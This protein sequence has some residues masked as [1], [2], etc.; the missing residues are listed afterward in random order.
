MNHKKGKRILLTA[1]LNILANKRKIKRREPTFAASLIVP[2]ED[3]S[4]LSSY[5]LAEI[6]S[7]QQEKDE[8]WKKAN[9][10]LDSTQPA[11][12]SLIEQGLSTPDPYYLCETLPNSQNHDNVMLQASEMEDLPLISKESDTSTPELSIQ[13]TR[14]RK[15]ENIA[16]SPEKSALPVRKRVTSRSNKIKNDSKNKPNSVHN[17][18]VNEDEEDEVVLLTPAGSPELPRQPG[19]QSE[20]A[21][22]SAPILNT[23]YSLGKALFQRGTQSTSVIGRDSERKIINDFLTTRLDVRGKGALYISGLPGTGKSALLNEVILDTIKDCSKNYPIRMANINCMTMENAVD[24]FTFIHRELTDNKSQVGVPEGFYED[25]DD[26]D[27]EDDGRQD[28]ITDGHLMQDPAIRSVIQDLE[29]RFFSKKHLHKNR[30]VKTKGSI[31]EKGVRHVIILD[32]LDSIMTRDQEVLFRIFQWAFARDSSLILFGIANALDLT[33]RFLPRLRSSSL[34]PQ[35]LP[36]KPYN[37]FQIISIISGRLWSLV[38]TPSSFSSLEYLEIKDR[39]KAQPPLIDKAAIMLCAKKIAANTGDLRKAF[40][41]CRRSLELVEEDVRRKFAF[42]NMDPA[43]VDMNS[44][45]AWKKA[46]LSGKC[47]DKMVALTLETAPRVTI[48]HVGRV[49]AVMFESSA[50]K[51]INNLNL[52]QKAVLCTLAISERSPHFSQ[53]LTIAKLFDRYTVA[54]DR[55]KDITPLGY[56]DFMDVV[57]ALESHGAVTVNGVCGRKGLGSSTGGKSRGGRTGSARSGGI[58]DDSSHRSISSTIQLSE[59]E[60]TLGRIAVLKPFLSE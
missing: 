54:C 41:I 23:V 35:L 46:I 59:L 31:S 14:K 34:T 30:G 8:I 50:A 28:I 29:K 40:D 13:K 42:E 58:A 4:T 15:M 20:E 1:I 33:D 39:S 21:E 43:L 44:Q 51:K 16:N 25:Y 7:I 12:T 38:D 48:G 47:S 10:S 17:D 52:Q 57:S 26:G 45:A 37:D 27:A 2:P 24:I 53:K 55:E 9:S 60:R 6:N 18:N 56:S 3:L 36:F 22:E 49:C 32:E 11:S 5:D 19:Q